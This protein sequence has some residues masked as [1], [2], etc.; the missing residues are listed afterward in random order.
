MSERIDI[1]HVA[2]LARLS[3]APEEKE[4]LAKDCDAILAYIDQLAAVPT[5]GI[6]PLLQTTGLRNAWR[7][8]DGVSIASSS[9]V[10]SAPRHDEA[11]VRVHT[12]LRKKK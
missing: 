2:R 1:N 4:K 10:D 5:E 12:V 9:L 7:A 11:F 3:L 8:D 6:E